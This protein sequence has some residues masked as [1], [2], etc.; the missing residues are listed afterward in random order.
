M[1]TRMKRLARG[2]AVS[3]W[4]S[5]FG[6]LRGR[7]REGGPG[8]IPFTVL[9]TSLVLLFGLLQHL[10][11]GAALASRA[12]VVC[13][14]QPLGVAL[15]RT[16]LSLF[17]TAPDLPIWGAVVQ[18]LVVFGIAE[19][20]LGLRMTLFVGYT[21]TLAGTLF[22][23]IGVSHDSGLLL[24]LPAWFAH[25]RDTGPSAAVVGLLLC[26]AWRYRAWYTGAAVIVVMA[27][28]AAALPN[29]AGL[30]H[31][32]A[33]GC[34]ALIVGLDGPAR[35]LIARVTPVTAAGAV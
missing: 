24:H 21:C 19:L 23:R 25:V 17:V 12:G 15:L 34:A 9:A 2:A 7:L 4:G 33:L 31:L 35:K 5:L 11:G 27:G 14:E 26:T 18:V 13:A 20:A 22:T 6:A 10:P 3:E 8:A 30:E 16:P 29:L 28:E 32:A 1:S